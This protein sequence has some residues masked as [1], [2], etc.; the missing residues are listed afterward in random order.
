MIEKAFLFAN[1]VH[2]GQI[3]K[4]GK[5]YISHPVMVA[6]VLAKNG[7]DDD[8]ICAG[9]LHDVIEDAHVTEETLRNEFNDTIVSLVS[10]DSEDKS[11]S[12]EERKLK[13]IDDVKNGDR[14]YKMLICADKLCNLKDVQEDI[15]KNGDAIWSR[16]KRG[17]DQQAWFHEKLLEA[18]EDIS[19]THM[20]QEFKELIEEVF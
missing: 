7:A 17:K 2:E 11:K 3:R 6:M 15:Q 14:S 12:W 1:K 5:T 16:F 9:L 20:Y 4:D 19:D 13:V 8:L 18:L 10:K